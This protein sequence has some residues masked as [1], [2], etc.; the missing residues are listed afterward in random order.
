LSSLSREEIID[1]FH[2]HNSDL[3]QRPRLGARAEVS[4]AP[5]QSPSTVPAVAPYR[6]VE[7]Q[8]YRVEV[9]RG[10][11]A[12]DATFKFSRDN[13]CVEVA[14]AGISAIDSE[15]QRVATFR[16]PWQDARRGLQVGDWVELIDDDWMPLGSPPPLLQVRS[17]SLTKRE[18]ALMDAHQDR[19]CDVA[20]HPFLR[21]WDQDPNTPAPSHGIPVADATG[22]WYELED[23]V[24]VQFTDSECH[25]ERGDFWL[26][27]A[28]TATRGILWPHSDDATRSP[29][30]LAPHGPMRYRAP[31][32]LA[33]SLTDPPVDLRTRFQRLPEPEPES[34]HE[35]PPTAAAVI[36]PPDPSAIRPPAIRFRLRATGT[37]ATGTTSDLEDG[38]HTVG[39]GPDQQIRLDHPE[40]SRHHAKLTVSEGHMTVEDVGSGNGTFVNDQ[41]ITAATEL[42]VDD[43]IRFG[44]DEVQVKVEEP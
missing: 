24:Q 6:G 16:N 21:R 27:P 29:L 9:H 38:E 2:E 39:R 5:D 11:P 43:V 41:R 19:R 37:F 26:I 20:L 32:A 17:V 18:V 3:R 10:G 1:A 12:E 34:E 14:L 31:L 33:K 15:G 36:P 28:R 13:G 30:A 23:G 35:Q 8:L 42:K 40:V 4:A 44:S 7:N 22:R 25:Y